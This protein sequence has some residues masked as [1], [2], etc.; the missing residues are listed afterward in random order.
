MFKK[1]DNEPQKDPMEQMSK[2]FNPNQMAGMLKNNITMAFS[3]MIQFAWVNFFFSGFILAKVPFP[4]TQQFKSNKIS[5]ACFR[6]ESRFRPWTFITSLASACIFWFCSDWMVF[7]I[8]FYPQ[9]LRTP[10]YNKC[11]TPWA[12]NRLTKAR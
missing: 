2:S 11:R 6:K 5:Q 12:R 9:K 8:L 10:I 4:L 1:Y 3:T 7:K